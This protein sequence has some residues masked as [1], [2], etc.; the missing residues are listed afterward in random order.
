MFIRTLQ[1]TKIRTILQTFNKSFCDYI[2]P[3]KFSTKD[4]IEKIN[5]E[6]VKLSYSFGAFDN[7]KLVGFILCGKGSRHNYKNSA[8][9]AIIGVVPEYR[10][11]GL[12]KEL[13]GALVSKLI[14]IGVKTIYLEVIKRN[15][16]AISGYTKI[17]YE[18]IEEIDEGEQF[19]MKLRIS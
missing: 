2:S 17:G 5:Q 13:H 4:L 7:N 19:L 9:A 11:R 6:D 15:K 1:E 12:L 10:R 14:E 8:Y 3:V 18:I 16:K